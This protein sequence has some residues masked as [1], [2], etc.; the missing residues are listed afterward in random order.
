MSTGIGGTK[1]ENTSNEGFAK[2]V[3]IFE[4]KV[5]AINPTI[6]QYK[7]ILG[8]ELKD[9]SKAAEYLNERDGNTVLR[10]DFWL[11]DVKNGDKFKVN[12]FLENKERTNKDET[13]HQYINNVGSC[14]WASDVDDLPEWFS[15]RDYRVAY[16]GEED[17]YNFVRTW[18]CELDYRSD[19]TTLQ[20]DWKKLMKGNVR[21]LKDQIDGDYCGNVGALATI[22]T[23]EKDGEVKEYQGIY[24]KSFVP[25]YALKNF[26][27]VDY[28]NSKVIEGLASKKSKDLKPHERFVLNVTGEYGCKDYYTFKEITDYNPDD[29]L[30]SSD[31]AI[32]EEDSDY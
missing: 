29:N 1:R 3:G 5:I 32:S 20:I 19:D 12:F 10:V 28:S 18:L 26:K 6:E 15:A 24:N 11:E 23:K 25:A 16:V 7:S 31:A 13:K 4:A 8:M 22:I 21:D 30:V 2:K 17:F 14:S 9:D 27:L